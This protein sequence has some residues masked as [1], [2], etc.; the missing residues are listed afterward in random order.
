MADKPVKTEQ[1]DAL[2]FELTEQQASALR[3][4]AGRKGIRIS[5]YVDGNTVKIDSIAINA[6]SI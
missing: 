5:G 1:E 6:G 4:I 3:A 2:S